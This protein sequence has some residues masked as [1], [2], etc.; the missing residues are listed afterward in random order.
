MGVPG[1][2]RGF[3]E[4]HARFGKLPWDALIQPSIKLARDGWTVSKIFARKISKQSWILDDPI[5]SR[6]LAP[7][8]ILLKEGDRISRPVYAN[9]LASLAH[10]GPDVFYNGWIA[11]EII[12]SI[13]AKGGIMTH[14]DL[15]EYSIV[16]SLPMVGTYRGM[17]IIT[18]PPQQVVGY[19]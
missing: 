15:K 14:D 17:N 16:T 11:D 8:G 2:L 5:M 6:V 18:A 1:E 12:N 13:Q 7:K 3:Q 19:Y 9:T 4:A 10:E